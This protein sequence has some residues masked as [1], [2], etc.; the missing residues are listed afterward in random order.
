MVVYTGIRARTGG[1]QHGARRGS[2]RQAA[3]SGA[4]P[5]GERERE[6]SQGSKLC[7]QVP[8]PVLFLIR[9]TM[10]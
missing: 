2:S 9:Q 6:E 3:R 7:L 10:L 4:E 5:L 8:A 1:H